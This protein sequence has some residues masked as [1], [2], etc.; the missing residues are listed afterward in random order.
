M[1]SHLVNVTDLRLPETPETSQPVIERPDAGIEGINV[2]T[3]A[4]NPHLII[5]CL[6]F[7]MS[8]MSGVYLIVS[9][10]FHSQEAIAIVG[11]LG[12]SLPDNFFVER[13]D[14]NV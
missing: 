1:S 14:L 13:H 6:Q 4:V 8:L 5:C 3:E 7:E 9:A 12:G 10:G 2:H 11:A